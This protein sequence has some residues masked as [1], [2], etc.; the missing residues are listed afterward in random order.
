MGILADDQVEN[1]LL[2]VE[3]ES[4]I[5]TKYSAYALIG[6]GALVFLIGF[7]GCCGALKENKCLLG[8]YLFFLIIIAGAE[9]AAGVLGFIHK[10]NIEDKIAVT[11]E[12]KWE[13]YYSGKNT[14]VTVIT[15]IKA[16]ESGLKCC[17]FETITDKSSEA[18]RKHCE[19]SDGSTPAG[20]ID[21]LKN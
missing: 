14:S 3:G 1:H 6:I 15:A 19:R 10:T 12:D 8:L 7:L 4:A 5:M 11:L 21:K 20:C 18:A 13:Q 2:L 16:V 17:N 9:I